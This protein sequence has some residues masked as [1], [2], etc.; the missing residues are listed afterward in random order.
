MI[1][2]SQPIDLKGK[3]SPVP[4]PSETHRTTPL[5]QTEYSEQVLPRQRL[6]REDFA[7]YRGYLDGVPLE[8]L[9][10]RYSPYADLRRTRTHLAWLR[11][12][13][14]IAARRA[15]DPA[16]ARLLR[17]RPGSLRHTDQANLAS[18]DSASTSGARARVAPDLETF[19]AEVD[20]DGFYSETEL[21]ELYGATFPVERDQREG[22]RGSRRRHLRERQTAAL[23]RLEVTLAELPDPAHALDTWFEPALAKR[24]GAAGLVTLADLLALIK[25]YRWR[26][27]VQVPRV[28]QKTA[29]R[30][31]TWLAANTQS[32]CHELSVLA[33]VP[34]RQVPTD[35]ADLTRRASRDRHGEADAANADDVVPLEALCPP[36][37]LDGTAG[38]NRAPASSNRLAVHTDLAAIRAWL[39]ARVNSAHTSRAYRREAERL[40]LWALIAKRK[41]FSSLTTSDADEYLGSFLKDPQP[42]AR[43]VSQRRVERFDVAW[44]P[45]DGPLSERSRETARSILRALYAW[46]VERRYLAEN[47]FA[48][49]KPIRKYQPFDAEGRTLTREQ[50]AYL[51]VS[52]D[53]AK[54]SLR[55]YRDQCALLLAYATGLRR[56]ELAALTTDHLSCL[57]GESGYP[58]TWA[59]TVGGALEV[60]RVLP[61]PAM[62]ITLLQDYFIARSLSSDPVA[63]PPGTPVLADSL[64]RRALTAH[65]LGYVFKKMFERASAELG[66]ENPAAAGQLA[67]ASTHW[68]RHS[69][70]NHALCSGVDLRDLRSSL[71]HARLATTAA[72]PLG[73]RD[74]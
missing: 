22:R 49:Q 25:R 18:T 36:P 66:V 28:G 20:P 35:H 42:A 8:Q 39:A 3:Q 53:R 65:G 34:R 38:T 63:W 32:L 40:V 29:A 51:L 43:W 17:L 67:C 71:G 70:A 33:L 14:S 30:I 52:V 1:I 24:L 21:L 4:P 56:A 69:Y 12:A 44:R 2:S 55:E 62:L 54:P 48:S 16:A 57:D 15:Q 19:R 68:L 59:I 61:I 13:L 10:A 27:Y 7:L 11:D 45:F 31:T 9:H 64:G 23:T 74:L 37:E 47:P 58:D 50:W 46:L 73:D 26:W 5:R 41:A 60:T 6:T 72:Y